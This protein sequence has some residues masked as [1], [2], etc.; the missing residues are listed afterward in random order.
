MPFL[1]ETV[2]EVESPVN[3][4]MQVNYDSMSIRK[5]KE[6]ITK[7]EEKKNRQKNMI[8]EMASQ[9]TIITYVFQGVWPL[10]LLF[11]LTL[12]DDNNN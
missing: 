7:I 12:D 8:R 6:K 5:E 1:E 9:V 4:K 2:E 10:S 11:E 3:L